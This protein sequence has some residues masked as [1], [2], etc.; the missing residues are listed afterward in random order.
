MQVETYEVPEVDFMTGE[1][2]DSEEA[3]A[4]IEELGLEGQ[5]DLTKGDGRFPYR[6]MT[7]EEKFVYELLF[8]EKTNV[9]AFSDGAIPLR[10]LQ[11]ISHASGLFDELTVWHKP[12]A[13]IKD[14]LLVGTKE[15]K[16]T[17]GPTT[18]I[19]ILSRWGDSLLPFSEL[20]SLACT[21][22]SGKRSSRTW[23]RLRTR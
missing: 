3:I 13:D 12:N 17:Y 2:E 23:S 9:R 7:S 20:A 15:V 18:E 6:K 22:S 1:E 19:F 5:Q 16:G 4:L 14:P 8:G 10:V 11:V 21:R